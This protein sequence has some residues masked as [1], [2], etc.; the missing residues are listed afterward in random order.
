[1]EKFEETNCFDVTVIHKILPE[2]HRTG[3]LMVDEMYLYVDVFYLVH[4]PGCF[5]LAV[6]ADSYVVSRG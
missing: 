5:R 6:K 1:M 4:F 3:S 2:S